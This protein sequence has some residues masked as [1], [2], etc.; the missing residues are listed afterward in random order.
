MPPLTLPA[1]PLTGGV[2]TQPPANRFDTQTET[3]DNTLLYI[4]RGTEK[5]YGSTYVA[6]FSYSGNLTDTKTHWVRR[7]SDTKYMILIDK[8]GA[9]SADVV[10]VFQDDGTDLAVT[11]S[12]TAEAYIKSGT[13]SAQ[14]SIVMTTYGDTT[15]ILNKDVTTAKT[16]SATTYSNLSN[17]SSLPAPPDGTGDFQ[18][19][20]HINLTSSE[21]GYPVG[22]YEI[23]DPIPTVEPWYTRVKSAAANSEI[24]ASTMPMRLV[25]TPGAPGTLD[26]DVAPWN[27]RLSGD[28]TLNPGPSFIGQKL[29]AIALFQDRLWL[30]GGQQ[31]ASSQAG[32]LYNFWV[33]DWTTITDA[34]PIDITLSG[35]SVSNAA[36]MVPFD[37][38]LVVLADGSQ[39]WELQALSSFTPGDT[40]L[41][42][43]TNYN[44]SNKAFPV[45][46][47]NQLYFVSEQGNYSFL[48]EYFPNFDR[49][50]N[51][52]DN[53]SQHVEEYL[54]SNITRIAS[55]ENNNVV[56]C[57]SE[58]EPNILYLYMT[59]WR[60]NEKVQSS[61]CRWVLDSDLSIFSFEAY[62]NELNV[63]LR[64]GSDNLWLETIPITPP[65]P[66]TDGVGSGIGYHAVVDKKDIKTGVYNSNTTE[67]VFTLDYLDPNMDTV[68]LGDQWGNRMGQE[69]QATTGESGGFTTLTVTGDFSTY[70]CIV[71]KSYS[72]SVQLSPPFIKNENRQPVQGTLSLKTLDILFENTTLFDVTVTPRGRESKIRRFSASRYGSALFGVPTVQ[73]FGRFQLKVRGDASDTKVV[74]SNDTPFPCL[75]TNLEWYA[76]FVP[77]K[78]D[79]TKR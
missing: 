30:A 28:D 45:K 6:G 57:W 22:I 71:G 9:T 62:D 19:G 65:P 12:A 2:S 43:T 75:F 58:D 50:A 67:T 23:S 3:S 35:Q 29:S 38:T 26:C 47:A 51:I 79:P 14:D 63:V 15:F 1:A 66:T 18:A 76:N 55:S 32:D 40:N 10:Q 36:F 60:V 21:V 59:S 31:V 34:D 72:M 70:P 24:D 37:R 16:G 4:N 11:L 39:Q 7:D 17:Q 69:I 74:I 46:I 33:D 44:V 61:W 5:R 42:D 56:F 68:I 52:G 54:P 49:D 64:D 73:D 53:V 20:Y 25:F 8:D 27:V 78:N 13:S 48:W 77:S 41:V